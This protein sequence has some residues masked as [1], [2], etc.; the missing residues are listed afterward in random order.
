MFWIAD[1]VWEGYPQIPALAR[2]LF[3]VFLGLSL[4]WKF[5]WDFVWGGYSY[6]DHGTFVRWKHER[7]KRHLKLTPS[8]SAFHVFY[9]MRYVAAWFILLGIYSDYAAALVVLWCAFEFVYDRKFHTQFLAIASLYLFLTPGDLCLSVMNGLIHRCVGGV[10]SSAPTVVFV[11]A[12]VCMY[13]GSVAIKVRSPQFLSGDVLYRTY[14]HYARIQKEMP[15]RETWYP[16]F[17]LRSFVWCPPETA[18]RRW[19]PLAWATLGLEV[20][21]P[22]LLL[23]PQSWIAGAILGALMHAGFWLLFPRR[24]LPFSLSAVGAYLLFL[25]PWL[26]EAWVMQVVT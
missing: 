9:A 7:L 14:S 17:M 15:F 10:T 8:P 16:K 11:L 23:I 13:L 21:V 18:R 20:A 5:S 1:V 4:V 26:L 2:D 19:K 6:F 3:R 22:I 24:L 25:D 12:I